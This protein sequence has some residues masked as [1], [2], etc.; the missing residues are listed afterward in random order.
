MRIADVVVAVPTLLLAVAVLFV[1]QPSMLNLVLVL[2]IS[3]LPAYMRTARGQ[4]LQIREQVF[5]EASRSLGATRSRIIAFDVAPLV[6]P[7]IMTVAMLDIAGVILA[8]SGLSFLGLG[9]HR[10]DVDWGML[11]AD[12]RGYLGKGWWMTV[13]PGLAIA[14][15]SLAS[16]FLSNWLRAMDDPGQ[17]GRLISKLFKK[18][19]DTTKSA[20]HQ[21]VS[22]TIAK[23]VAA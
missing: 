20:P 5:I 17:S 11:V 2:T 1:L 23:E 6:V 15:T 16:N 14:L 8:A 7:P 10:P 19:I 22:Q 18:P 9:L 4:T 21:L 3:R 12:G 13:F